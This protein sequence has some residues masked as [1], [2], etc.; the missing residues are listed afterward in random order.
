LV[1]L[2]ILSDHLDLQA[3]EAYI[4]KTNYTTILISGNDLRQYKVDPV[5]INSS[6]LNHFSYKSFSDKFIDH[7][8]VTLCHT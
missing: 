7:I 4:D 3:L 2:T 1:T 6:N 8:W 5:S